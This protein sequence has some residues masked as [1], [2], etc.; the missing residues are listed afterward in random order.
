MKQISKS[1]FSKLIQSIFIEYFDKKIGASLLRKIYIS[2]FYKND[3]ALKTQIELSQ[4][5]NHSP[6]TAST[7]YRKV[8]H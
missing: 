6:T 3:I 2:D 4:K 5:M 8:S 1:T 7:H